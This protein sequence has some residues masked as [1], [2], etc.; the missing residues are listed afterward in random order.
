MKAGYVYYVSNYS[1]KLFRVLPDSILVQR[2]T[3]NR[4]DSLTVVFKDDVQN[5]K[6]FQ[7][8]AY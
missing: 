8:L 1:F 3:G 4:W 2:W 7:R 6:R 5:S